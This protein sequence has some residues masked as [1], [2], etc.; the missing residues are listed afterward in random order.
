MPFLLF[1]ADTI[2]VVQLLLKLHPNPNPNPNQ[3]LEEE[4]RHKSYQCCNFGQ[5]FFFFLFILDDQLQALQRSLRGRDPQPKPQ[6]HKSGSPKTNSLQTLTVF[7][8]F[9]HLDQNSVLLVFFPEDP[10]DLNENLFYFVYTEFQIRSRKLN[11]KSNL[12]KGFESR[13][14]TRMLCSKKE[15]ICECSCMKS[16]G[17]FLKAS[18]K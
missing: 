12:E 2:D 17:F 11:V 3:K 15:G 5:F 7:L 14:L 18:P 16:C 13:R 6:K 10:I 1:L 9:E 8:Q 4:K